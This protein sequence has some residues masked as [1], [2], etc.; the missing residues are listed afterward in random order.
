MEYFLP[1]DLVVSDAIYANSVK[2][3]HW[4]SELAEKVKAIATGKGIKIAI[5]DTGYTKHVDGP[6]PIAAK[7][8]I[9]GQSAL[10]DGNGHGT[11]VAGTA[12]GR[13]G[14]GVAPDADL[15]VFKCLSDQGSGSSVGIA[16]GI[17]WAAD[18][19]AD[20]ISLSLGGGGSDTATNQAIDYAFSKGCIVNAAA[21]NAGYNGANTIGWPGKYEGCICCGAYQANGQIANFSSGGRE[22][23]FACPGQ[24]IISFSKNGSGYTSMSGT[25]MA[26]PF[27]SGLLAC[28]V[29]VMRRQGK[30]QWT[31]AKSVNEFFKMNL[32]D[33][34]A[35]GFDPRFGH[36]IP[37]ADSLLQSL[38]RSELLLA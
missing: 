11:H 3:W 8:F 38:L 1:P 33:A 2:L 27:G 5:G 20:I 28:I 12:L 4:P 18:E 25:S 6:E 22:I 15:I 14:I 36:G 32:K 26:T 9:S 10:R 21:G 24:D 23:D 29:E 19:G 30:P 7:S 34:G 16:N 31:A 37:V 35:P 17:R 13:N